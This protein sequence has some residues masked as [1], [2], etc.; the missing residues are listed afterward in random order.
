MNKKLRALFASIQPGTHRS[1]GQIERSVPSGGSSVW[2][3][4]GPAVA[5]MLDFRTPLNLLHTL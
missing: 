3:D 1:D 2:T 5:Q 4:T